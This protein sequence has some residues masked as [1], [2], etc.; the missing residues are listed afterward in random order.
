M[1]TPTIY[2][3]T[4]VRGSTTP[5]IIR[6]KRGSVAIPFN[7]ARL[8]VYKERGKTLAFKMDTA[9]PVSG[10]AVITNA[11]EG[12]VTFTPTQ[13]QTRGLTPS[14]SVDAAGRNKYEVEVRQGASR[15]IYVMGT[16]NAIGGLN[17]DT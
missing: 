4:W 11:D 1:T 10:D 8:V 6:F 9:A 3:F 14:S 16:I 13:A 15:E 17:E 2:D 5:L 7:S 12:E